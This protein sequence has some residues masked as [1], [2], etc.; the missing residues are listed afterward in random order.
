LVAD[1]SGSGVGTGTYRFHFVKLP[2]PFSIPPGDDGGEMAN[3][4]S[5]IGT[6]DLGD[7]DAWSFN[8]CSGDGFTL[9]LDELSGGSAFYLEMRLYGRDGTLLNTA[10]GQTTAQI[11]RFAPAT[12][13]YTIL[14]SDGSGSLT[15][16]GT[17]QLTGIG[18]SSG[19][20]LCQPV[21]SGTNVFLSAAGGL[22]NLTSV[23]FTATNVATPLGLWSPIL[24]NQFDQFGVFSRTNLFDPTE[25]ARFFLL[26]AQ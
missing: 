16:T 5:F 3:G 14:V 23:L 7:I 19:L 10:S 11:S 6:I 9:Q 25:P 13:T 1:D 21:V 15:G 22:T 17:Y 24:T 12:G 18:I 4:A 26:Q 8:A 20:T 2:G